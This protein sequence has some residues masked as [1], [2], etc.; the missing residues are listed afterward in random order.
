MTSASADS[1]VELSGSCMVAM[2]AKEAQTQLQDAQN[3][4]QSLLSS[5]WWGKDMGHGAWG[6]EHGAW[7]MGQCERANC[8]LKITAWLAAYA[9]WFSMPQVPPVP[10][11]FPWHILSYVLPQL[12]SSCDDCWA[13]RRVRNREWT[14]WDGKGQDWR[15]RNS[16]PAMLVQG[17]N[18]G[19]ARFWSSLL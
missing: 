18:Q 6:M 3:Q 14:G 19:W 17:R 2:G 8:K 1:W 13:I 11:V 9:L 12:V 4:C 15:D 5:V 7:G 10:P 16:S